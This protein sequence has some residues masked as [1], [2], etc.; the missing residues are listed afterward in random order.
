MAAKRVTKRKEDISYCLLGIFGV[1]MSMIY[2]EGDQAFSR[3]QQEIMRE[4]RD[5]SILAW[6]LNLTESTPS[7]STE[8]ISGGVLA[9]APSDFVNRLAAMPRLPEVTVDATL[10]LQQLDLKLELVSTLLEE[11][12]ILQK[13][14]GLG[15]E[16]EEEIAN[17]ELMKGQL[18]VV[19]EKLRKLGDERRL[20]VDRIEKGSQETDQLT[21]RGNEIG[22]RRNNLSERRLQTLRRLDDPLKND[23]VAKGASDHG[24][25][26]IVK[27]LT[28]GVDIDSTTNDGGTLLL[29][30]AKNGYEV[31][32]TL[33][34][35]TGKVDANLKDN[36]GWTPLLCASMNG[37]VRVVRQLLEAGAA[38]GS[39]D[40]KGLTP[41]SWAA[42]NGHE[43]VVT[44]LLKAGAE[45][46]SKDAFYG[47]TPLSLAAVNSREVVVK[48][49]LD[50]GAE[51][52]SKDATGRKP[53]SLAAENRHEAG[54][55]FETL[56]LS[57][58]F[59]AVLVHGN[60]SLSFTPLQISIYWRSSI[61]PVSNLC[62]LLTSL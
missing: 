52:E 27:M 59:S 6:G 37:Y 14:K 45:L 35:A 42:G 58:S 25:E 31:V 30:A 3:L 56:E 50:N 10:E 24:P 2:G 16:K 57:L 21:I 39:K 8:V 19:E 49:L 5:D 29:W 61:I 53:L 18:E 4:V 60:Y 22:Q 11:S 46:E 33:L 55:S 41:L 38:I 20:L 36:A 7:N 1:M 12:K 43:T 15:Q 40:T 17:L 62:L 44:L 9:T 32:V 47:Q 48:L 51:L 26:A 34:L 28:T 13:A 54:Q 23:I